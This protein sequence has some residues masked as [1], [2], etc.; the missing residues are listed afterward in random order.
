MLAVGG[1]LDVGGLPPRLAGEVEGLG[2]G[3]ELVGWLFGRRVMMMFCG[4]VGFR[5]STTV[6]PCRLLSV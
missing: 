6:A 1:E 2:G 5:S 3:G 4:E